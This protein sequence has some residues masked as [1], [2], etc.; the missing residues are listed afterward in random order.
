VVVERMRLR[1]RASV[2]SKRAALRADELRVRVTVIHPPSG[3]TFAIQ[4]GKSDLLSPAQADATA[5]AFDFSVRLDSRRVAQPRFLGPTVHG[6]PTARFIY[7]NSG[8]RAGQ[9]T[10][11]WDRR[12]K[13]PLAAITWDTID[14]ARDTPNGRVEARIAGSAQDGGPACASVALLG[15]GWE[16]ISA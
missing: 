7:V 14:R 6:P 8:M 5:L 12:A 11:C 9:P 1:A 16:V 15:N 3:V 4:V 2:E 10:S 13:V